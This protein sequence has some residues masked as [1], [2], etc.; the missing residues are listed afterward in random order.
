M[1][2]LYK[3]GGDTQ[4]LFG[5]SL[6]NKAPAQ[7]WMAWWKYIPAIGLVGW[8]LEPGLWS[9][10]EGTKT[11]MRLGW[12]EEWTHLI[13]QFSISD[14]VLLPPY[15][16]LST[17]KLDSNFTTS[18]TWEN[19]I[20]VRNVKVSNNNNHLQISVSLWCAT[21]GR[22]ERV[23]RERCFAFHF[24]NSVA[25]VRTFLVFSKSIEMMTGGDVQ[26]RIVCALLF[27][28]MFSCFYVI[29]YEWYEI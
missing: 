26:M 27:D 12:Y 7:R 14:S 6:V 20:L 2:T 29:W 21:G 15:I 24:A 16:I 1:F 9:I 4:L 13:K 18:W 23:R 17:D 5:V 22:A 10:S 8:E 19:V 11:G 25:E 28:V 3:F